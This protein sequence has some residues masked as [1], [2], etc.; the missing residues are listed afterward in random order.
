MADRTKI[1]KE[2]KRDIRRLCDLDHWEAHAVELLNIYL[3]EV[4]DDGAMWLTYGECL[5]LLY[6]IDDAIEALSKALEMVPYTKRSHVCGRI[7]FLLSR[8]GSKRRSEEWYERAT[9][10][11]VCSDGWVWLLRGVNL[12]EQGKSTESLACF[13]KA[14]VYDDVEMSEV[15]LNE[16]LAHR[17]IGN[18]EKASEKFSDAV[19]LDPEDQDSKRSLEGIAVIGDTEA[20]AKKY[21]ASLSVAK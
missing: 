9:E 16:G 15:R 11:E 12:L 7:G 4:P 13:E 6:R 18:F 2:L 1:L 21:V 8:H 14:A 19:A 3:Q 5:G 17:A 20:Q 10:N